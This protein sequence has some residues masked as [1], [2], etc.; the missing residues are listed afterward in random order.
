VIPN[1]ETFNYLIKI[2]SYICN[3]QRTLDL[4]NSMKSDKY[5]IEP[6]EE[7]YQYIVDMFVGVLDVPKAKEIVE[8]MKTQFRAK[9]KKVPISIYNALLRSMVQLKLDDEINELVRKLL[10]GEEK[11]TVDLTFYK[12]L[13]DYRKELVDSI[14]YSVYP[15]IYDPPAFFSTQ[16]KVELE[17]ESIELHKTS[18][19]AFPNSHVIHTSNSAFAAAWADWTAKIDTSLKNEMSIDQKKQEVEKEGVQ[20][21]S[22]SL[23]QR[24][25]H[26]LNKMESLLQQMKQ[27][28]P[29]QVKPDIDCY[30]K[31]LSAL[32]KKGEV[33]KVSDLISTL[34]REETK[35]DLTTYEILIQMWAIG[36]KDVHK[37]VEIVDLMRRYV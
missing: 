6:N 17:K 27:A 24:S 32:A 33:D 34:K 10:N 1:L 19:K 31:Y 5:Q 37:T 36:F 12:I 3:T 2:N 35:F 4:F 16:A 11:V 8:E 20:S 21:S 18:L 30:N 14:E 28:G 13:L 7:T 29:N 15:S 22:Q 9:Q 25:R 26:E 23:I